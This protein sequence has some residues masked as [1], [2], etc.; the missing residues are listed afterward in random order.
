MD[1]LQNVMRQAHWRI[2]CFLDTRTDCCNRCPSLNL[3]W[4]SWNFCTGYRTQID[5]INSNILSQITWVQRYLKM[6][7]L[8]AF[9]EFHHLLRMKGVKKIQFLER[10]LQFLQKIKQYLIQ[11]H[12]APTPQLINR[13]ISIQVGS[14]SS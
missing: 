10:K 12:L 7:W 1:D 5:N 8:H 13:V 2:L 6:C 14:T 9:L 4:T 3:F 11:S